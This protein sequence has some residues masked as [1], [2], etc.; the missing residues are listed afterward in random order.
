MREFFKKGQTVLFQG[1]SITDCGRDRNDISSLGCGY[2]DKVAK[3]Y[4]ALF[5]DNG[6]KFVNKG[7]S[8]DRT[9]DVLA[10]YKTDILDIKPD[11]I[12]ILIG[13][14]DVWRRYDDAKDPTPA[15][16]F[17]ENYETILKNIKRDLPATKIMII[18]PFLLY[19]AEKYSWHED[20]D[21]KLLVV[22][23]LA[24][25][26][27]DYYISLNGIFAG[28]EIITYKPEELSGDGVHPEDLGHRIIALEYLKTLGII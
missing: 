19:N 17:R 15:E 24:A 3:I 12:S 21:P 6:V 11:F 28:L 22:R 18:E 20:L 4:N 26:Y 14:N 16:K 5:A 7:V 27:A 1:D 13:I 23:E 2:P 9:K 25:K 10:R 8:G